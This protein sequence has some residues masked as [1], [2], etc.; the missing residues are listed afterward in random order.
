MSAGLLFDLLLCALLVAVALGAVLVRDL[1]AVVMLFVVLG[2]FAA[3]AWVRLGAIDVALAEASIGAGLTG[4]LLV[5]AAARLQ[6]GAARGSRA[7]VVHGVLAAGLCAAVFVALA[8][9]VLGPVG[10]EGLAGAV[11][12]RLDAT[13]VSNPVTAVLLNFR[14][15]DTLLETVVLLAALLAAWSL[16]A[17]EDWGARPGWHEHARPQGQMAWLARLL[18]P[19]GWLVGV[20]LFWAGASG[21]GG[22]FQAGTVLAAVW[23]LLSMAGLGTPAPVTDTRLRAVLV[24]GP[25]LF[26]LFAAAAIPFGGFLVF[27][28]AAAKLAVLVIEATLT[29]S[30]AATLALLVMGAPRG[31]A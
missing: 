26:L 10:G 4:V 7:A 31:R 28:P 29:L 9:V 14:G 27:P 18:P 6:G 2:L 13:G 23:L 12:Q 17:D 25:L 21:P 20:H 3:V 1:M 16:C 5:R 15:Y 24:A 8:G 30:I 19:V 22:A 11:D